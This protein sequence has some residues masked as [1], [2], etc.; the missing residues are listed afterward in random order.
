MDIPH[1]FTCSSVGGHLSFHLGAVMKNA[2][3]TYVHKGLWFV[4]KHIFIF[5]GCMPSGGLA[6]SYGKARHFS[7]YLQKEDPAINIHKTKIDIKD[8]TP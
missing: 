4:W 5:L 2:P 8:E 3:R 6:G 7:P 1:L